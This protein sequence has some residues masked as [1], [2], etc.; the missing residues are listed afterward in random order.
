[1]QARMQWV[2]TMA[3]HPDNQQLALGS[4]GGTVELW[5]INPWRAGWVTP[6][7]RTLYGHTAHITGLAFSADGQRLVSAGDDR[8][9]KVWDTKGEEAIAL[10]LETTTTP[11]GVAFSPDGH[12]LAVGCAHRYAKL[13]DGT[14]LLGKE[15]RDEAP[16]LTGHQDPV[17]RVAFSPDNRWLAS[18]SR[19][20]TAKIWNTITGEE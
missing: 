16:A 5:D 10:D 1:L 15:T 3:I 6:A 17:L 19:D 4:W 12:Q 8:G 14:P 9:L 20:R 13:F 2:S 7:I 18:A 11:I